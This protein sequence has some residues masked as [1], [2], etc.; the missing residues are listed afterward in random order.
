M[1]TNKK[2]FEL[3][4]GILGYLFDPSSTNT[5]ESSKFHETLNLSRNTKIKSIPGRI[6]IGRGRKRVAH[7]II[8]YFSNR[9]QLE[10]HRGTN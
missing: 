2:L 10:Y 6:H 4:T 8:D 3:G 1:Q 5:K 9:A 7:Q